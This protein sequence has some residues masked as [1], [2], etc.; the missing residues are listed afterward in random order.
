MTLRAIGGL[1]IHA[2]CDQGYG[3]FD[4]LLA[5]T[6]EGFGQFF[7]DLEW[8]NL[9]GGQLLTAEDYPMDRLIA[10][11]QDFRRRWGLEVYLE[12]GTAIALNAG[13]LVT[14]VLDQGC[15]LS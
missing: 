9:G 14:E 11:L 2:L 1:H 3:P 12:P 15:I 5:A 4:R 6:E 8:I 7:G 13:A 10:R